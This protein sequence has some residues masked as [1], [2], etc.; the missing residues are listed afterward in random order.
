MARSFHEGEAQKIP[1]IP[2]PSVSTANYE[3]LFQYALLMGGISAIILL[4]LVL[5]I[6]SL[7]GV[8]FNSDEA[9]YAGQAAALAD[10]PTLKEIFP[11][12]RS[13]PLLYQYILAL[14]FNL[15][16]ADWLARLVSAIFGVA[17]VFLVYLLGNLLYGRRAGLT[18]ALFLAVMPYHVI[19]SRQVILDGP[20]TFFST[21]T[22][23]LLAQ[24]ALTERP[25]WLYAAG[26]G[27]GLTFL[28]K[29]TGIV[30]VGSIYF[31]LALSSNIHI[32][33]R[34][35]FLSTMIMGLII[36]AF[37]LAF[38]LAG[39]EG[40]QR[41]Q[42]Y[43]IWQFFRNPNHEFDFYFRVVPPVLGPF[44]ILTAIFGLLVLLRKWSWRETLL[45]SWVIVPAIFFQFWP[46]KGFQYLIIIAPP[47][48]VLG[49]RVVSALFMKGRKRLLKRF[50][51]KVQI[52]PLA[53]GILAITLLIPSL[54][55]ISSASSIN[56]LAGSGGV[57]GGREAGIWV[58]ENIPEGATLMTIGPSMAN[59]LQFYGHRVAFGLSVS[60]NP[61]N[62]N[63][64]YQPI[65]N[66]DYQIRSGNI[67]YVVW[68][69]FS[70][71]RSAFFSDKLLAYVKRYNGRLV[72]VETVP[73]PSSD[74]DEVPIIVIY[75]VR[76]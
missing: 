2:T 60:P 27:M 18:A 64:S 71:D 13:H 6:Y 10:E 9:V 53:A 31:F 1:T 43:L 46:T 48:S 3:N 15:G 58:R 20:M 63:P 74:A 25:A 4:A 72:H 22:L 52:W 55:R 54:H 70:A 38:T 49:G 24:F 41:S 29:E 75:E 7:G 50:S 5:R 32:R 57:P 14:V 40:L 76:P 47:I 39:E 66:P 59:I 36:S 26:A 37:P 51:G 19:V 28:T 56:F 17:T 11:I 68:D 12:F 8:G 69:V 23:L 30:L 62:R 73:S 61:L 21:L 42:Q 34:D 65:R 35:L 67:Q 16:V 33:L 44:L 45:I